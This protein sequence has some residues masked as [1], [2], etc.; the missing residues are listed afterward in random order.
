MGSGR[1]AIQ[2]LDHVIQVG[3]VRL[4]PKG[5]CKRGKVPREPDHYSAVTSAPDAPPVPVAS[6]A[7]VLGP[8]EPLPCNV[9][10]LDAS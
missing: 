3:R 6:P 4:L 2:K 5:D 9:V 10:T 1:S 8:V 7:P